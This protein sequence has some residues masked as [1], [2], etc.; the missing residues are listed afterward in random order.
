MN[1][2]P[3][4]GETISGGETF[5]PQC[6][7]ALPAA[8]KPPGGWRRVITGAIAVTS[9]VTGIFLTNVVVGDTSDDSWLPLAIFGLIL[10][11]LVPPPFALAS[12]LP[13]SAFR[14]IVIGLGAALI[15]TFPAILALGVLTW[16][17]GLPDLLPGLVSS[18]LAF[19]VFAGFFY[20][21]YRIAR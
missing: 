2:C 3:S 13:F 7:A 12:I 15:A 10:T 6:G 18:I 5:C 4:C 9:F 17:L 14:R 16:I 11:Y 19:M 8:A 20:L 1:A 21:G